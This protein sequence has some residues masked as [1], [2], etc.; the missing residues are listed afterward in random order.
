MAPP[1]AALLRRAAGIR[2]LILDVDG[3]LTDG[4]L[5]YDAEGREFKSFNVRDGYG[6]K[7]L[8]AAGFTVAVISGR[9]ST[10]A[11]GRMAD[12]DIRHVML[13]EADKGSAL[14]TLLEKTGI[15]ASAAACVGDD[16]PDLPVMRQVALPIAV[17]D[18]HPSVAGT[19]AWRTTLAGGAGAVRE[20]CDLLLAARAARRD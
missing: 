4:R 5:H 17:A 7:Q 18:C 19:A 8:M 1:D 16:E 2:L 3:V 13:G 6:I 20:V 12:L 15:P 10:S 11:A 14:A 9:P